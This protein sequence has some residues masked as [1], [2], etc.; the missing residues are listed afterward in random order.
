MPESD[1]EID[2]PSLCSKW[3]SI[4]SA[5]TSSE[6]RDT[7]ISP[8]VNLS[9]LFENPIRPLLASPQQLFELFRHSAKLVRRLSFVLSQHSDRPAELY[10]YTM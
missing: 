10:Y 2:M 4:Y 1:Y 9:E 8:L 7:W 3:P 6:A 5:W